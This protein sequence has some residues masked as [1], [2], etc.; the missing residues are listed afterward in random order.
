MFD[1]S[2][3]SLG[4]EPKDMNSRTTSR[5]HLGSGLSMSSSTNLME[6]GAAHGEILEAVGCS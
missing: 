2:S 6:A 5:A 3:C 4:T 1:G